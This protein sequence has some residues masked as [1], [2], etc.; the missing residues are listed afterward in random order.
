MKALQD[1]GVQRKQKKKEKEV[2]VTKFSLI[3]KLGSKIFKSIGEI[4]K[5]EGWDKNV[6]RGR[7]PLCQQLIMRRDAKDVCETDPFFHLYAQDGKVYLITNNKETCGIEICIEA[8]QQQY[9]HN[10]SQKVV[11][12]TCNDGLRLAGIMLDPRYRDSVAGIMANK[13]GRKQS[14]QTGDTTLH[15]FEMI[16]TDAFL[17]SDYVVEAPSHYE[18]FPEDER[19]GWD[20]NDPTIFE[21]ERDAKWLMATWNEYIKPK[22]K[23]CLDNWNS[24]TG[25]GNGTPPSIITYTGANRWLTYVYCKDLENS[26]ILASGT[27]GRMPPNLQVEAGFEDAG[28]NISPLSST[29][30]SDKKRSS[31]SEMSDQMRG[32]KRSKESIDHTLE[33]LGQIVDRHSSSTPAKATSTSDMIEKVAALSKKMVEDDV[34]VTMS[35]E[36]EQVYLATVRNERRKVVAEMKKV[37][38][39]EEKIN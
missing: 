32:L 4:Y 20:P 13:K 5:P 6:S 26:L 16:L 18:D 35:P 21:N 3:E 17:N 27:G 28:S 29:N 36:T 30:D 12:R 34:L 2:L 38:E 1:P 15:F 31:G 22:Y 10:C 33:R 9:I 39:A 25:G 19:V 23:A 7:S 14:D 11:A 24:Q 37:N 8:F